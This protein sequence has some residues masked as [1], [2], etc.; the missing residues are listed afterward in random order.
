MFLL[1]TTKRPLVIMVVEEKLRFAFD[2]KSLVFLSRYVETK[3]NEFCATA[4]LET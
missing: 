1:S 4:S 3:V 2:Q